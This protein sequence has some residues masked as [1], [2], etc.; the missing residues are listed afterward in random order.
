MLFYATARE[1]KSDTLARNQD[2]VS[3]WGYMSISELLFQWANIFKNFTKR[4]GLVHSGLH[5]HFIENIYARAYAYNVEKLLWV[6]VKQQSLI[7][8]IYWEKKF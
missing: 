6:G 8:Q 4:V 7:H 3:E 2:N 1:V 5:H